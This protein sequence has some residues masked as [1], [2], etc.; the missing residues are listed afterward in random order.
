MVVGLVV[1]VEVHRV[2]RALGVL[3]LVRERLTH[4][5]AGAEVSGRKAEGSVRHSE[6]GGRGGK[7][8]YDE[9]L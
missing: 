7:M 6:G 1:V 9:G 5:E 8:G 3:G 2:F 4:E